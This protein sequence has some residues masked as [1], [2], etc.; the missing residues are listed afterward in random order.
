MVRGGMFSA[1][2]CAS[3]C[4][5][6]MASSMARCS[7]FPSVTARLPQCGGAGLERGEGERR[8]GAVTDSGGE[9]VKISV[10]ASMAGWIVAGTGMQE[11]GRGA[12]CHLMGRRPNAQRA[13]LTPVQMF[14]GRPV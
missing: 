9:L 7:T 6:S 2:G 1:S 13:T 5:T 10:R 11:T 14:H 12:R 8:G 3:E 4:S